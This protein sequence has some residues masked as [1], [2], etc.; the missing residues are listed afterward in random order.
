MLFYMFYMFCGSNR[1]R[2]ELASVPRGGTVNRSI[3]Q[4]GAVQVDVGRIRT[5]RR[6]ASAIAD[7]FWSLRDDN[8]CRESRPYHEEPLFSCFGCLVLFAPLV[9]S[10]H[11]T[12]MIMW[13]VYYRHRVF[14][15]LKLSH[16]SEEEEKE[17]T[18]T[19]HFNMNIHKFYL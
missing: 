9:C 3:F 1:R 10:L 5:V 16:T 2:L 14:N 15:I 7:I 17:S 6:N 13:P 19:H 11:C 18:K 4:G 8:Q 12:P